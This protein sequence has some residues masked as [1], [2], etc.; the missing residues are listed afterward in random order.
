MVDVR[1]SSVVKLP[2]MALHLQYLPVA[3][4]VQGSIHSTK[5]P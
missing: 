1:Y 3:Y 5:N 4:S 2:I